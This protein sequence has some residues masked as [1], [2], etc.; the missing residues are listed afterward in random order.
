MVEDAHFVTVHL[1]ADEFE[2]EPR[3]MEPDEITEWKWFS[4]GD[5][6]SP[7]YKPSEKML[8]NF[9]KGVFCSD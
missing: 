1:R 3:V 7:I 9:K 5:L 2:G 4:L 8:N 6:P